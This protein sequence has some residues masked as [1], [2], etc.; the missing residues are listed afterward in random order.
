MWVF[1]A[2]TH[3]LALDAHKCTC[4]VLWGL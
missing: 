1:Y 4:G 3:L 2:A